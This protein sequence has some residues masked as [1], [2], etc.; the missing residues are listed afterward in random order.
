M[1]SS[2]QPAPEKKQQQKPS[3]PGRSRQERRFVQRKGRLP[4]HDPK[5]PSGH[6]TGVCRA[7]A[8]FLS[9]STGMPYSSVLNG[10]AGVSADDLIVGVGLHGIRAE[11]GRP[12]SRLGIY[13]MSPE[14]HL[15]F[16]RSVDFKIST[17]DPDFKERPGAG[18]ELDR[19]L[20]NWVSG[21]LHNP[22]LGLGD[23][24]PKFDFIN[25]GGFVGDITANQPYMALVGKPGIK[26]KDFALERRLDARIEMISEYMEKS[27]HTRSNPD[28]FN[29]LQRTHLFIQDQV[30]EDLLTT[31]GAMNSFVITPQA[32][33]ECAFVR[34]RQ[35]LPFGK[36]EK[37]KK[38]QRE[39]RQAFLQSAEQVDEM[40]TNQFSAQMFET[41]FRQIVENLQLRVKQYLEAFGKAQGQSAD[42]NF[43]P[44]A[45]HSVMAVHSLRALFHS[46]TAEGVTVWSIADGGDQKLN[47]EIQRELDDLRERPMFTMVVPAGSGSIQVRPRF[48]SNGDFPFE[49]SDIF[50]IL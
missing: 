17:G 44:Y 25:D 43:A 32:F 42:I 14:G 26:P 11:G 5:R 41:N 48:M 34:F 18:G 38:L 45:K 19:S 27:D 30:S 24:Y 3:A 22:D 39:T 46:R 4:V 15:H 35:A 10:E 33:R 12:F 1:S 23:Y 16:V 29:G 37:L 31:K 7:T 49:G 28:K 9:K 50:P 40:W 20:A 13:A 36:D 47:P 21:A 8:V 6:K 2:A